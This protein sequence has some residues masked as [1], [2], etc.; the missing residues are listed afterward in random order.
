MIARAE[1]NR[2]GRWNVLVNGVFQTQH[3]EQKESYESAIFLKYSYPLEIV[4]I[5]PP[6]MEIVLKDTKK[7]E[8][9][10]SGENVEMT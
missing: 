7:P 3:N 5:M 8:L 9:L 6:M 10:V 4:V 1:I 2:I